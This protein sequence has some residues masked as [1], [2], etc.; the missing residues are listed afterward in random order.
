METGLCGNLVKIEFAI[1]TGFV[2]SIVIPAMELVI[3]TGY[4]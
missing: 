3:E 4:V 2:Y 1:E